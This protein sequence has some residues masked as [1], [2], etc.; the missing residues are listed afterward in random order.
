MKLMI[1][2]IEDTDRTRLQAIAGLPQSGRADQ[3]SRRLA[4]PSLLPQSQTERRLQRG[5]AIWLAIIGRE[6]FYYSGS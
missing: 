3:L 2:C 4:L 5:L 6:A 1:A